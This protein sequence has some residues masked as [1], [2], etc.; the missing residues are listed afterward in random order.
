[1]SVLGL[2]RSKIP[3]ALKN[4]LK[5]SWLNYFRLCLGELKMKYCG[6]RY[7]GQT[8]EDA[9]LGIYLPEKRVSTLTLARVVQLRVQIHSLYTDE[10]GLVFA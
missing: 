2:L 1:M 7:F 10:V 3:R 9:I 6:P 4:I 8:A 5:D